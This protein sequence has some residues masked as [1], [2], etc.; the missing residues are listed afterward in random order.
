MSEQPAPSNR[1]SVED[2]FHV[3][4]SLAASQREEFLQRACG[5]DAKLRRRVEALLRAS[6][7]GEGFLPEKPGVHA[8][9][10]SGNPSAVITERPGDRIGNYELL[11]Q[12]GAGG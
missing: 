7:S 5:G 3:A 9:R 12:I 4:R 8:A 1:G 11:E 2:I 6:E 10:H